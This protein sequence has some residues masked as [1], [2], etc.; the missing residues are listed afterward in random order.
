MK[1]PPGLG[2]HCGR[3]RDEVVSL[4]VDP[5]A[6]PL[7]PES[8]RHLENCSDCREFAKAWPVVNRLGM[9]WQAPEPP[10]GLALRTIAR[11]NPLWREKERPISRQEVRLLWSSGLAMA[12]SVAAIL[13][14][15]V[16]RF[17]PMGGPANMEGMLKLSVKVAFLQLGGAGLVSLIVLAVRA[18]KSSKRTF[19]RRDTHYRGGD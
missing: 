1:F 17:Y 3:V 19:R 13:L 18:S 15:I 5:R 8:S 2:R 16:D 7:S 11:V 14:M 4:A 6:L 9:A 10:P 12:G